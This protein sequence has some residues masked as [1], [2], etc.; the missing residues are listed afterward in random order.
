MIANIRSLTG[1]GNL[2]I[3]L[4]LRNALGQFWNF[5]TLTWDNSISFNCKSFL[6]EYVDGDPTTSFYSATVTL[7]TTA[8][9]VIEI[10][11][12]S[13]GVVLQSENNPD[14]Y[15]NTISMNIDTIENKLI[16]IHDDHF[17]KW[18]LDVTTNPYVLTKYRADG[19]TVLA[20]FNLT[21]T[22]KKVTPSL[23]RIPV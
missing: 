7:P 9:F 6:N 20:T 23:Q 16:D 1:Q 4:R 15:L 14:E 21:P 13:T 3:Y 2:E 18:T 5:T 12:D 19:I 17:G 8:I 11:K 10:V 22:T